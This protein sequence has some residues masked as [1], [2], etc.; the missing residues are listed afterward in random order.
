MM[1]RDT[2]VKDNVYSPK[3]YYLL[4]SLTFLNPLA[5]QVLHQDTQL[6]T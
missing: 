2:F 1:G 5:T 6:R 3:N 4:L